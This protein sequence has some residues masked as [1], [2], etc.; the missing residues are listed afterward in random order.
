MRSRI[1]P[2]GLI[3]G[4]SLIGVAEG[5]ATASAPAAP[6]ARDGGCG[7]EVATDGLRLRTGPGARYAVV[8]Q[9]AK[10]DP[11]AADREQS[12]WYQVT[13]QAQSGSH[14]G[15]EAPHGLRQGTSGWV[16]GRFLRKALC[17]HLD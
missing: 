2:F 15:K 6:A 10:G 11:V 7:Y 16:A 3:V 8:G 9:L 13:L 17:T 14:Y 1:I 5:P 12:G 4:V